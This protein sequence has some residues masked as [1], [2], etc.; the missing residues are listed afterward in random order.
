M[1]ELYLASNVTEEN[2]DETFR[3]LDERHNNIYQF[4]MGYS[5][6]ILAE[7]DYGQGIPLTMI[8]VHTLTYIEDH[9]DVTIT[10]L[11]RMWHKTKSALSQ[12]IS[13]LEREGLLTK[14]RKEG[15]AREMRLEL[16]EAGLRMSRAHKLYDTND[17]AKTTAEL[18]RSCSEE[19]IDAFYKVLGVFNRVMEEDFRARPPHR[20]PRSKR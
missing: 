2:L 16:T 19:E 13:H 12:V 17:I 5:N 18:R 20:G 15:N 14:R 4:V 6:Y 8:E 11:A 10:E 7:H 1:D 3:V 9:P